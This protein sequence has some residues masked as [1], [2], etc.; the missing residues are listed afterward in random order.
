[1]TTRVILLFLLTFSIVNAEI[2]YVSKA[3]G[4]IPPYTS[5]ATAADSIQKA[6]DVCSYGDT[7]YVGTG[8]YYEMVEMIQGLTLL[9]SGI[10]SSVI[11]ISG[12]GLGGI[13]L[14][15]KDN[16]NLSHLT[17]L[18]DNYST[19]NLY[20]HCI[21]IADFNSLTSSVEISGN[22]FLMG[23][24]TLLSSNLMG[25]ITNNIII[26]SYLGLRLGTTET[27]IYQFI[28]DNLIS[29]L[30]TTIEIPFG[31]RPEIRNNILISED[32]YIFYS[33]GVDTI[34]IFN[35]L[36][37]RTKE[38]PDIYTRMFGFGAVP[39]IIENNVILGKSNVGMI[40]GGPNVL[41]NNIFTGCSEAIVWGDGSPPVI[42]YNNCW[43]NDYN[44][45]NRPV[46]DSTNVSVYPMF[47]NTDSG[48]YHLQMFSPLI[49]AGD[50]GILNPDGSRSDIGLYGGPF[51]ES[52]QYIDYPPLMPGDIH[53]RF[54]WG[55][56]TL[57]WEDNHEAD[58]S[59][60]L[61]TKEY[62]NSGITEETTTD[63]S[64]YFEYPAA[65][66]HSAK[67]RVSSVDRQGNKSQERETSMVLTEVEKEQ[68]ANPGFLLLDNYP[69][70][71]NPRTKIIFHLE[72]KSDVRLTIYDVK[73]EIIAELMNE[74]KD[75]GWHE[76]EYNPGIKGN[77]ITSGIYVYMLEVRKGN[78]II[79]S[80]MGKMVCLK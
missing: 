17:I 49:N 64:I 45:V 48:D 73:G 22:K 13:A 46:N 59:H 77:D 34:K 44:Y 70:P 63:T 57:D 62:N 78:K 21:E 15:M 33:W 39:A 80:K 60:Y 41:R 40:V 56:V 74:S 69:N 11:D 75:E 79:Y 20:D 24:T 50:P 47:A 43:N 3:G 7:V 52:Y 65:N 35:N 58:F 76:V 19:T 23:K 61:I 31:A 27:Y 6:V 66:I 5:W 71:F 26:G 1:M 72:A 32:G 8:V 29:T 4:S 54:L 38:N 55:K 9:G 42:E 2:R 18:C 36:M 12:D 30:R 28:N 16:T 25:K 10:D 67:Y 14:K 51:G 37:V 53:A 68:A